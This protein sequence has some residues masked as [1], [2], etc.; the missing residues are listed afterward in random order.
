M[1]G[2]PL[3][4]LETLFLDAG[5]TLL[6]WDHA[7]VAEQARAL[8][9]E[10]DVA[11]LARAE[12]AAR[13][14]LD[15]LLSEGRSTEAPDTLGLW[16]GA[17]LDLGFAAELPAPDRR[18]LVSELAALLRG[19]EAGDRLWSRV[20]PGLAEA[21]AEAR[22]AGLALVVVSN[23]D[24]TIEAKLRQAGLRDLLDLVVDSRLVGVE[25][26]DPAI[27]QRALA[28]AGAVPERTLHVGDL[29]SVDVLGARAARL[30]AALLDP[31]DDWAHVDCA[32]FPDTVSVVRAILDARG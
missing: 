21:L 6:C 14:A 20:P 24:G 11:S 1:H 28:R 32:R 27:F 16:F 4:S 9:F 7:F 25:K 8:G 30:H 19:R 13:P 3:S 31:H 29:H 26:P 5:N 22:D 10:L 18:R 17:M 23:S 2:L 15:R 12:A